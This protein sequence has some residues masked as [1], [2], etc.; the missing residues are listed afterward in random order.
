[1]KIPTRLVLLSLLAFAA[2]GVRAADMYRFDTVHSQILFT[3]SHD[4]FSQALGMLHIKRGWLRFDPDDWSKSATV[5]DIDLSGVDMGDAGW[6][7]VVREGSLLDAG[8]HPLAHFVSTSVKK[9]GPHDGLMDGTLTLRG[10]THKVIIAF[11]VN[12]VGRTIFEMNTVAGFSG[13]AQLDRYAFGISRNPG[14]IGRMVNVGLQIEALK[15][16]DAR[17]RYEHGAAT[18]ATSQ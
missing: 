13:R 14:S 5:L 10:H 18:H 1:M 9:T 6:S 4:G 16:A 15:D 3:V 8:D 7:K 11:T 2:T 17:H 12:R